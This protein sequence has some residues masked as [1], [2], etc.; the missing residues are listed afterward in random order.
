M[1]SDMYSLLPEAEC[2]NLIQAEREAW[3]LAYQGRL[4]DG[5]S[6]LLSGLERAEEVCVAGEEWGEAL[7]FFWR[8]VVDWYC[9]HFAVRMSA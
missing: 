5:Y 1:V 2:Q 4:A 9:D 7:V 8:V 6:L 3:N